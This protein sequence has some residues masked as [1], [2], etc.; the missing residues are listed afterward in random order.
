MVDVSQNAYNTDYTTIK[1]DFEYDR[2]DGDIKDHRYFRT[3]FSDAEDS[4]T[5]SRKLATISDMVY[6]SIAA[7]TKTCDL[8]EE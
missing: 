8:T 1:V 7:K 2:T 4:E 6:Q 5:I 3:T